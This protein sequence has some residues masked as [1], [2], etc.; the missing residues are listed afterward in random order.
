MLLA[1]LPTRDTLHVTSL[2][3]A[4]RDI[5]GSWA[6]PEFTLFVDHCQADPFAAPSRLRVQVPRTSHRLARRFGVPGC[7]EPPLSSFAAA[8]THSSYVPSSSCAQIPQATARFP[9]NT[10]QS[11]IRRVVRQTATAQPTFYMTA[12]PSRSSAPSPLGS[13][14]VPL[15]A[16]GAL[17]LPH[18]PPRPRAE[19]RRSGHQ[20]GCRWRVGRG[21]GCATRHSQWASEQAG[22]VS[23]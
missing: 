23:S 2:K 22:A 13:T 14:W 10:W 20:P 4:Y 9:P 15:P 7:I 18:A 12:S 8:L 19:A 3:Q 1:G 17:R 11:K 6:F 16:A 21:K 5:E